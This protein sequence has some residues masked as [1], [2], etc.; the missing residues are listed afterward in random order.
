[1]PY[2]YSLMSSYF[3]LSP[4]LIIILRIICTIC[5]LIQNIFMIIFFNQNFLR[6]IQHILIIFRHHYLFCTKFLYFMLS[7]YLFLLYSRLSSDETFHHFPEQRLP[8]LRQT[9]F[10]QYLQQHFSMKMHRHLEIIY[11]HSI[12]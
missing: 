4:R 10:V 1:M 8:Y 5:L 2:I 12:H 11:L 9:Y 6:N 7:F 3:P